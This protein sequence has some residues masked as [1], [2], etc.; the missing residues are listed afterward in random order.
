[1]GDQERIR[2]TMRA[3][4]FVFRVVVVDELAEEPDIDK[5]EERLLE[6]AANS[7]GTVHIDTLSVVGAEVTYQLTEEDLKRLGLAMPDAR[8]MID[9]IQK[10]SNGMD[11]LDLWGHLLDNMLSI[12]RTGGE[13]ILRGDSDE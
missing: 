13:V 6:S 4:E 5:L 2:H 1:M 11:H 10:S 12:V 9:G 7:G 8:R 3:T